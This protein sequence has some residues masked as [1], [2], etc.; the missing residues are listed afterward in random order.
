MA[1]QEIPTRISHPNSYY[2]GNK[3]PFIAALNDLDDAQ[4]L[5]AI[6]SELEPQKIGVLPTVL[7]HP[8]VDLSVVDAFAEKNGLG[9]DLSYLARAAL[10]L[11]E[12]PEPSRHYQKQYRAFLQNISNTRL[13]QLEKISQ[14]Q[15]PSRLERFT[16]R[17]FKKHYET[18]RYFVYNGTT[19]LP[20]SPR[21]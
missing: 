12:V 16:F 20:L 3:D 18:Y 1:K 19:A 4:S 8:H 14:N 9:S 7:L 17:E 10:K 5:S 15:Q 21:T 13:S 6:F 11:L 2:R